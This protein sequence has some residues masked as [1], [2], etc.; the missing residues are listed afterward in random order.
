MIHDGYGKLEL[1]TFRYDS[2]P[3]WRLSE[4]VADP[5]KVWKDQS[6]A[7]SK[8]KDQTTLEI[9]DQMRP[10]IKDQPSQR[11]FL[12]SKSFKILQELHVAVDFSYELAK[13]K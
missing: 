10:N 11:P 4:L 2:L 6:P 9:K 1:Q 12:F 3:A 5:S 8:I 7:K 13:V